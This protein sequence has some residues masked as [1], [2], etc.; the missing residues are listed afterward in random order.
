VLNT[1]DASKLQN[2]VVVDAASANANVQLPPGPTRTI[3][4]DLAILLN[5]SI[6]A[7]PLMVPEVC[8]IRIKNT[9]Y[10]YRW[11]NRDG[12]GGRVYNQRKAQGFT[13]ASTGDV[14]ILGGD[15]TSKDGEIRA[16]DLILMKIQADR[17]DAAMKYNMQKAE[18]MARTR[19]VMLE[20]GSSDVHSDE[21]PRRVSVSELPFSK[22]GAEPFIPTNAEEIMNDSTKS[23]RRDETMAVVEGLRHKSAAKVE[24]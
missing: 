4:P 16:G 13:N 24:V 1:V 21:A 10:R 8:S 18:S 9:E 7:R 5:K 2:S 22:K 23:G 12:Q 11:V 20:G 6:V 14:E 19:G 15:A 3:S 17:Y